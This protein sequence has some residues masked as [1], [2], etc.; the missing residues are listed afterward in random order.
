MTTPLRIA[1]LNREYRIEA[2]KCG[3]IIPITP[4]I[5]GVRFEPHA[6]RAII[7]LCLRA[8]VVSGRPSRLRRWP[9]A[10]IFALLTDPIVCG[11][12]HLDF[13]PG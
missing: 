6:R 4:D 11:R 3:V 8:G 5:R 9:L 10:R 1:R 2:V 13:R 7:H 12:P